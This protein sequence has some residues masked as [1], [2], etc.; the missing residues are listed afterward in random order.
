LS[1]RSSLLNPSVSDESKMISDVDHRW[2]VTG[3]R[4]CRD[5][6]AAPRRGFDAIKLIFIVTDG[7]G[8]K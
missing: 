8:P 3:R 7:G 2:T 1:K 5:E 6:K 4:P